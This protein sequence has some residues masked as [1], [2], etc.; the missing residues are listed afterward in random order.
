MAGGKLS[1]RQKMINMMYLVLMALLAL[2]VS[3][4]ILD[5]FENLRNKLNNSYVQASANATEFINSMKTEIDEEVKNQNKTT[6][7]GLKDTLDLIAN[8]SQGLVEILNSHIT[9]MDKIAQ[10]DPV[11]GEYQAKDQTET[12]YRYWMGPNDLANDRRGN[13]KASELREEM[14]KYFEFLTSI[15]NLNA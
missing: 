15:Y 7:V 10:L 5:A 14:D 12:N 4:E 13:G 6:N 8:K 11:T 2:N 1:P 9:E 3:K